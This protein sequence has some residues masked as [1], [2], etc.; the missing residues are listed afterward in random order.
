MKKDGGTLAQRRAREA[1]RDGGAL[2]V[3]GHRVGAHTDAGSCWVVMFGASGRDCPCME[4][5]LE[6]QETVEEVAG[7]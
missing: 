3:C 5:T 2:C 1:A 7:W 6:V 4:F